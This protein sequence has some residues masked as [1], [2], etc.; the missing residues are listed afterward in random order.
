MIQS[1]YAPIWSGFNYLF[2]W[3]FGCEFHHLWHSYVLTKRYNREV[4]LNKPNK[5]YLNNI[6]KSMK[7]NNSSKKVQTNKKL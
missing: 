5:L 7:I 4:H 2:L 3:S 1:L 6:I